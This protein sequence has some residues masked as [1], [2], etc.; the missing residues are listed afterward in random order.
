VL[1]AVERGL[2]AAPGALS[3]SRRVLCDYGNMSSATV[4]FVLSEMMDARAA[5][6]GCAMAFGPGL[7]V[8]AMRFALR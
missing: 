8:E 7:A 6:Q 4:L 5:G 2:E 1:D 3:F